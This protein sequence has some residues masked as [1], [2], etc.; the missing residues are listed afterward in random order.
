[1]ENSDG[2]V[3]QEL[4][5]LEAISMP[6]LREAV[7]EWQQGIGNPLLETETQILA[8]AHFFCHLPDLHPKEF[9]LLFI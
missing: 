5:L 1:M 2:T 7:G 3:G 6:A 9:S 4:I 8:G